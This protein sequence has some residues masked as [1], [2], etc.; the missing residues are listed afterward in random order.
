MLLSSIPFNTKVSLYGSTVPSFAFFSLALIAFIL[1]TMFF[2]D[3]AQSENITF[4]SSHLSS[5]LLS[6]LYLSSRYISVNFFLFFSR[7]AISFSIACCMNLS[8]TVGTHRSL[9]FIYHSHSTFITSNKIIVD[10]QSVLVNLILSCRNT[11]HIH[12]A[13]HL[14]WSLTDTCNPEVFHIILLS[15][16]NHLGIYNFRGTIPNVIHL[17]NQ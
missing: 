16:I 8:V 17:A 12:H 7:L 14:H 4:S 2:C 3:N 1:S 9:S 5:F 15:Y 6:S 10:C 13:M 11:F